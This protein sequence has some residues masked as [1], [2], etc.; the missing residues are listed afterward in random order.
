MKNTISAIFICIFVLF[1][2][3]Q[4]LYLISFVKFRKYETQIKALQIYNEIDKK[5]WQ[6]N[7]LLEKTHISKRNITIVLTYINLTT[8]DF[9]SENSTSK[10]KFQEIVNSINNDIIKNTLTKTSIHIYFCSKGTN[11]IL[12]N[13]GTWSVSNYETLNKDLK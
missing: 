9:F 8:S 13:N 12:Y 7:I 11:P 4:S 1:S 10:T 2:V 3:L 5:F 6:T